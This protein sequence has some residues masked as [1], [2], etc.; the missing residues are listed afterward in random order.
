MEKLK[1][2]VNNIISDARLTAYQDGVAGS[3]AFRIGNMDFTTQIHELYKKHTW[4]KGHKK[5]PFDSH[6]ADI[7]RIM[8]MKDMSKAGFKSTEEWKK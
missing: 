7:D 4:L 3:V 6:P 8:G 2:L 5:V 1:E